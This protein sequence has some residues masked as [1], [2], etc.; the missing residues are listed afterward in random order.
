M[1]DFTTTKNEVSTKIS[2]SLDTYE[3]YIKL[4]LLYE[5]IIK[6]CTDIGWRG[7]T[8]DFDIEYIR[9]AFKVLFPAAY[10]VKLAELIAKKES[11]KH[12]D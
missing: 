4:D 5:A 3:R 11:V 8:I 12:E 7:D 6:S 10:E 9:D 2:I 1:E